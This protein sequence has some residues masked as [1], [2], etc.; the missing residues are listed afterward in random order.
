MFDTLPLSARARS[1]TARLV[2]ITLCLYV[3][4][5]IYYLLLYGPGLHPVYGIL[6]LLTG[7]SSLLLGVVGIVYVTK[8]TYRLIQSRVVRTDRQSDLSA[9]ATYIALICLYAG[10]AWSLLAYI[11]SRGWDALGRTGETLAYHV[12]G[13]L[14]IALF[15]ATFAGLLIATIMTVGI[16]ARLAVKYL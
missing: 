3:F 13:W 8:T 12:T 10:A 4:F 11:D 2:V 5:I 7:L 6:L 15:A 16:V 9:D 1:A 14:H